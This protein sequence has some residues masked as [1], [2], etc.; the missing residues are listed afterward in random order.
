[1]PEKQL[2]AQAN[3]TA[4]GLNIQLPK[5]LPGGIEDPVVNMVP[6]AASLGKVIDGSQLLINGELAAEGER[7]TVDTI[8]TDEQ[9]RRS[10]VYANLFEAE[11]APKTPDRLLYGWTQL[12]SQSPTWDAELE[13]RGAALVTMPIRLLTPPIGTQVRIPFSLVRIEHADPKNASSIFKQA[14]GEFISESTLSTQCDLAFLLPP[15]AVP[16]DVSAL[17]I[18]WDIRAPKRTAKLSAIVEGQPIELTSIA[19]PSIPWKH[20]VT[21]SQVLASMRNGRLVLRIEITGGDQI[22]ETTALLAGALSICVST[23]KGARRHETTSSPLRRTSHMI[24]THSLD[25]FASQL[26]NSH[27]RYCSRNKELNQALWRLHR[28]QRP[29][30]A[31]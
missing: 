9:R 3:L 5:D 4:D 11:D 31:C 30:D 2:F 15:E 19:A 1:M 12:W 28:A 10:K 7:W 21:D 29:H 26:G 13:R 22:E 20:S 8:V 16:L 25:T 23:S 27:G 18:D 6:G 24:R 17:A 14:T